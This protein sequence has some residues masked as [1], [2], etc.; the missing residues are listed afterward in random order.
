MSLEKNVKILRKIAKIGLKKLKK[1]CL[2]L[3][4]STDHTAA[5]ISRSVLKVVSFLIVD[6]ITK[7]LYTNV[8]TNVIKPLVLFGSLINF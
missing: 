2:C 4:T 8:Y 3:G 6:K 7:I 1:G 5:H